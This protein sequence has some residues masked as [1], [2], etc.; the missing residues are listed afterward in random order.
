MK[1][2]EVLLKLAQILDVE[3]VSP[4]DLLDSF[5]EWDSLTE[6]SIIA[7]ADSDLNKPLTVQVLRSFVTITDLV[8]YLLS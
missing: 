2:E 5:D 4:E 3:Q 7:M 6:L 8:S 1:K